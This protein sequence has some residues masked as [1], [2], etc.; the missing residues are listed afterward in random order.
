MLR[1]LGA[2]EIDGRG[3]IRSKAQRIVLA[4]LALDA[5][6]VV[7]SDRLCELIWGDD[8]PHDPNA[9]LQNHISRL[10]KVLPDTE[11]I[12][13]TGGGYRLVASETQLDTTAF[14]AALDRARSAARDDGPQ[15]V[16]QALALWRGS[17]FAELDDERAQ[18]EAVRL[19]ELFLAAHELR[20]EM[21]IARG[22]ARDA[23]GGLQRQRMQTPLRERTVQLLMI[24]QLDAGRKS[25]ALATYKD[26][27]EAM[28]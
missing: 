16:A 28:I 1:V 18:A 10:R 19:D 12:E 3:P 4:A 22:H 17:P 13:A 5:G 20:A 14:E 27:R 6:S 9:S 2:V 25:D 21:L 24:A 15:A 8:E 23:I 7:S 11:V 26:H